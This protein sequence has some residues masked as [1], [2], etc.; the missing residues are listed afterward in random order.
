ME[1]TLSCML[2]AAAVTVLAAV[3]ATFEAVSTTD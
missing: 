3:D 2:L 1:K